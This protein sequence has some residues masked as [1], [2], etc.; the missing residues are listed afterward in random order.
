MGRGLDSSFSAGADVSTTLPVL[1]SPK[2]PVCTCSGTKIEGKRGGANEIHPDISN[3]GRPPDLH[4]LSLLSPC[5]ALLKYDIIIFIFRRLF[6]APPHI[7]TPPART[8]IV[9]PTIGIIRRA[10]ADCH[11]LSLFLFLSLS[12]ND[13]YLVFNSMFGNQ[14]LNSLFIHVKLAIYL[15]TLN[16]KI[17]NASRRSKIGHCLDQP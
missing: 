17:P 7:Q 12:L 16:E 9:I 10:Q 5:C 6:Q 8:E 15:N 13:T 3:H 14:E 2:V 4:P 1:S 11:H